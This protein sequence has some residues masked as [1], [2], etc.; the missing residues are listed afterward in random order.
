MAGTPYTHIQA[1]TN[2]TITATTSR[3][4]AFTTQNTAVG[5]LLWGWIWVADHAGRI[6]SPSVSD[7]DGQV[8]NVELIPVTNGGSFLFFWHWTANADEPTITAMWTGS[9][10]TSPM[11]IHEFSGVPSAFVYDT[12]SSTHTT[13]TTP[14]NPSI[15]P[16]NDNEFGFCA[17]W[18]SSASSLTHPPNPEPGTATANIYVQTSGTVSSSVYADEWIQ[19]GSSVP[20]AL[21]FSQSSSSAT[22]DMAQ[23]Y[24]GAVLVSPIVQGTAASNSPAGNSVAATY[25]STV[26]AGHCLIATMYYTLVS[27]SPSGEPS[28]R[29]VS[30]GVNTWVEGAHANLGS[31]NYTGISTWYC[32]SPASGTPT[33]TGSISGNFTGN[34]AAGNLVIVIAETN[35]S[36]LTGTDGTSHN[37]SITAS[38]S[39]PYNYNVGSFTTGSS[40][41]LVVASVSIG[42]GAK[43]GRSVQSATNLWIT[44][45]SG[46]V[47]NEDCWLEVGIQAAAGPINPQFNYALSTTGYQGTAFALKAASAVVGWQ[48]MPVFFMG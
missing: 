17:Y 33:V 18:N 6:T 5:N 22:S 35:V 12:S 7:S 43:D 27:R 48:G 36:G 2:T 20:S 13:G 10:T 8:Y 14:T 44:P 29:T 23:V 34:I 4:Q 3:A 30:D 32:L 39:G 26:T 16:A 9:V 25:G 38:G 24:L 19:L 46:I 28:T 45:K 37:N 15:T 31:A 47:G 11:C 42:G 40:G 21:G 41:D 1:A